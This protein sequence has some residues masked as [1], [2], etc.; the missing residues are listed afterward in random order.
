M[1]SKI[2]TTAKI[3]LPSSSDGLLGVE[4]YVQS[5]L[6]D[7]KVDEAHHG[8]I[9]VAVSEAAIN[10]VKHGN[11]EDPSKEFSISYFTDNKELIFQVEDQGKGFDYHNIPDPTAPEN[12]EKETGRGVFLIRNLSDGYEF[13]KNGSV[14]RISFF[15]L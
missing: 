15:V 6:D 3:S 10:A 11:Q 14:L 5:V 2:A 9:L 13:Q 1:S 4:P 7:M 12:L 8:N